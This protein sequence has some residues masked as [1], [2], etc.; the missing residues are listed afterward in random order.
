MDLWIYYAYILHQMQAYQLQAQANSAT[1]L[2][3]WK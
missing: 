1:A 3:A 2:H